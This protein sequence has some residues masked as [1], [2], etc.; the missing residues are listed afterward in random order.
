MI[1]IPPKCVH[2]NPE[3]HGR[4]H[5]LRILRLE[6]SDLTINFAAH[7]PG[8]DAQIPA[9]NSTRWDILIIG[10]GA[11]GLGCAVDAASRGF[12]TLLVEQSDF[13]KATS[14][15]STKLIHG[16][17]RYLQQGNL[18]LVRESLRE[19]GLLIRNAPHLVRR[20]G[21]IVPN[22]RWWERT[23]YGTGLKL[24]D[25]LAGDLSL[26]RAQRFPRGNF[27]ARPDARAADCAA[28]FCITTA[29]L[30][31]LSLAISLAQTAADAGAV[32][33]NYVQVTSLAKR[34]N[35]ICGTILHN[36]E[37]G[38]TWSGCLW[39]TAM[40]QKKVCSL[41]DYISI[42]SRWNGQALADVTDGLGG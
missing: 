27:A 22:Y 35:I 41:P 34:N 6:R 10:G 11:T 3:H 8:S 37:T 20:L 14:S 15:R 40:P 28:E 21:F 24:Y 7:E 4:E 30:M 12:R 39:S 25:W 32:A 23:Y 33:A 16:G 1:S 18:K 5:P 42:A 31:T 17:V 9:D 2:R 29:S 13:G 26:G 36:L 38:G 19:R